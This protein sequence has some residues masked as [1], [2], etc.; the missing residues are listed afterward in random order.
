MKYRITVEVLESP[1]V[2]DPGGSLCAP[3][4]WRMAYYQ[5]FDND[6]VDKVTAAV[7]LAVNVAMNGSEQ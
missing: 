2:Y 7:A 6:K 5:S 3:D 4:N 1:A